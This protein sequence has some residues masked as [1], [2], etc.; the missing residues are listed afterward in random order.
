MSIINDKELKEECIEGLYI[1]G[2]KR[3]R[4]E[5]LL[6]DSEMEEIITQMYSAQEFILSTIAEKEEKNG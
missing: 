1:L 6:T 2:I 4:A 5:E 3:E